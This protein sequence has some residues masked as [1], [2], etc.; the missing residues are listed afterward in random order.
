MKR[1]PAYMQELYGGPVAGALTS[2]LS[3]LL[4][5]YIQLTGF[6][7]GMADLLLTPE[8]ERQR[9]RNLL[10]AEGAAISAGASIAGVE[11]P[12]LPAGTPAPVLRAAEHAVRSAIRPKYRQSAQAGA[13]HDQRVSSALNPVASD[14]TRGCFPGGLQRPFLRNCMSLMTT[15]GVRPS[16][17]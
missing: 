5:K 9:A 12:P 2:G 3:R 11:L 4:T 15:T 13:A 17:I 8:H 10:A 1:G 16:P 6:T 14:V 7:C